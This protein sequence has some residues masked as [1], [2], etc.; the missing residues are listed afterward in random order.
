MKIAII[1]TNDLKYNESDMLHIKFTYETIHDI[2][3]DY[4][5]FTEVSNDNEMMQILI[6]EIVANEIEYPI[7]TATA[8]NIN[9]D[10]YLICHINP[11]KEIYEELKSKSI[12]YNGIA[13]YLTDIGIKIYGK[14]VMFRLDTEDNN[15][16]LKNITIDEITEIFISKFVHRGIILN[17]NGTIDQF[18]FIFNPVDWISQSEISK[19]KFYE[20]EILGK[21]LMLFIDTQSIDI[22]EI[23]SQIYLQTIKG[24]VIIGMRSQY[25]DMNDMEVIYEDL[26]I[27]TFNKIIQLCRDLTQGRKLTEQEDLNGQIINGKRNY[28]NFHKIL[29]NRL[30]QNN[31][32]LVQ[33]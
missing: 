28:N 6:N 18:K 10:L 20:V 13:S 31:E 29:N 24:R 21:V 11:S 16:V 5:S 26:D 33:K 32:C 27:D 15:Y 22:N 17:V 23:A 9:N 14:A 7:H 19:Y 4:I 25:S 3:S 1:D 12:K 2:L 8:K 30:V